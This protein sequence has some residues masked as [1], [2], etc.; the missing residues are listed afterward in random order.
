MTIYLKARLDKK[1][2][3]KVLCGQKTCRGQIGW[4][5]S[6][7]DV[8]L[9]REGGPAII[10]RHFM[11]MRGFAP[12]KDGIWRMSK[13]AQ[14]KQSHVVMLRRVA[15]PSRYMLLDKTDILDRWGKLPLKA[16]CTLCGFV[17][18]VTWNCLGVDQYSSGLILA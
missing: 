13:H 8:E 5:E 9:E 2:G 1:T 14:K 15:K 18:E 6:T 11:F 4:L 17:N 7:P 10:F 16:K 3:L 12:W